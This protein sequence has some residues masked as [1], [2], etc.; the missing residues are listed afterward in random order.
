M[1]PKCIHTSNLGFLPQEIYE[2]CT[3]HNPSRTEAR[4]QGQSDPE[5]VCDSNPRPEGVFTH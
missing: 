3:G 2:I 5:V 4:G 1:I